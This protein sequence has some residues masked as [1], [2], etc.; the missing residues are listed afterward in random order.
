M[1]FNADI[2]LHDPSPHPPPPP[3]YDSIRTAHIRNEPIKIRA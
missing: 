1:L 2:I 3:L